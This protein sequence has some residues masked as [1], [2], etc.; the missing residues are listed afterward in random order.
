MYRYDDVGRLAEFAPPDSGLDPV[1]VQP[2]RLLVTETGPAGARSYRYDRAGRVVRVDDDSGTTTIDYD[3][4]GRR[5]RETRPDASSVVYR[6]DV[7]DRLIGIDRYDALEH[8]LGSVEVSYD[9]LGRPL[10]RRR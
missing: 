5:S 2:E 10:P 3:D 6:W 7:F 8:I 1:H 4:H 9:A